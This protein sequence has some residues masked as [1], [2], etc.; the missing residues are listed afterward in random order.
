V[1]ALRDSKIVQAVH[2]DT[3]EN[4]SDMFTKALD[5]ATFIRFRKQLMHFHAIPTVSR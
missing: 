5:L 4:L 2:V 1:Q 3:T